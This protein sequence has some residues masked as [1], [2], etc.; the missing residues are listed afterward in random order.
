M[1][2]ATVP[3]LGWGVGK[4]RATRVWVAAGAVAA[5]ALPVLGAPA[6]GEGLDDLKARMNEIQARL[7]AATERIEDLRT[8]EEELRE[9]LE[10]ID[11]ETAQ[12][13]EK[14]ARLEKKVVK[15]AGNLYRS[16]G[17]DVLEALLTAD[18]FAELSSRAEILSRVS[19]RDTSAFIEYSRTQDELV[20]LEEELTA[21][22]EELVATREELAEESDDLQAEFAA[23]EDDY[24][25]LKRKIAAQ[26]AAARQAAASAAPQPAGAPAPEPIFVRPSGS[27]ACPVAGPVSFVDSWGAPRVGHTHVGVDMMAAYG[28]PVVAIVSG[29]ITTSSYQSSAG[30]YLILSGDDGNAYYYMHNQSNLVNGGH[31]SMGQQIATVGDTG[32]AVGTPHLHFEYHPGGGGPVNPYPLVASIC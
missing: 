15:V 28:T 29:T 7:D 5:L 22:Q 14:S 12:L 30:N 13:E 18:S 21:K 1:G 4:T 19:Q 32:N 3:R 31:V 17:A 6:A 20:A 10:Q 2:C 25:E 24:E 11:V 26:A 27:M 8:E 9:R 23:A 16:G